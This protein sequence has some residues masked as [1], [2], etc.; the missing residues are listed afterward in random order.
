MSSN[1]ISN[2]I[3]DNASPPTYTNANVPTLDMDGNLTNLSNVS[4]TTLT[5]NGVNINSTE[6]GYL[7]GVVP[8]SVV[9]NKALVVDNANALSGLYYLSISGSNNDAFRISNSVSSGRASILFTNSGSRS[10]E[11]GLRG[12]A[13]STPANGFYIYDNA[14]SAYR[15][16]ID[17][18]G[19]V[20]IGA[21]SSSY[22]LHVVGNINTTT[23]YLLNDTSM[24]ASALTGVSDT[25][26][27]IASKALI[28]DSNKSI[29]GITSLTSTTL[30]G[31]T[32]NATSAYQ[33]NGTSMF[34]SAL[35]GVSN[36]SGAIA[37]KA[38][39]VDSNKSI[40]G[41]TSLTSTSLI[42]SGTTASTS[43][44][45]G[46][47]TVAGGVGVRGTLSGGGNTID[48][49]ATARSE[50]LINYTDTSNTFNNAFATTDTTPRY[51]YYFGAPTYTG[52]TARTTTTAA[53]M[54]ISGAPVSGT[55]N[56]ITNPYALIIGSG[57][58]SFG[59][60]TTYTTTNNADQ[61]ISIP[62]ITLTASG[63]ASPDSAHRSVLNI[64]AP[65]LTSSTTLTTTNAS[66]LYIAGPP[67]ASGSM[68]ITNAYSLYINSG[69]V[70]LGGN[71][72]T[73][74][75]LGVFPNAIP[76]IDTTRLIQ[77]IDSAQASASARAITLGRAYSSL[78]SAALLYSWTSAGS[79][80]NYVSLGL[81]GSS[82]F[83]NTLVVH[84]SGNVGV[85]TTSPSHLLDINGTARVAGSLT[86][87]GSGSH[88][89]AGTL[90][91]TLASGAQT[92]ITSVGTLSSLTVS[93]DV[94]ITTGKL[95]IGAGNDITSTI[96]SYIKSVSLGSA[97]ASTIVA[98][99]ASKN[100]SGINDLSS[101]EISLGGTA[102]SYT[103]A[104]VIATETVLTLKATTL[105]NTSAAGTDAIHRCGAYIKQPTISASNAVITTTASTVFIDGPPLTA[106]SATITNRYA[107]YAG[108]PMF[109]QGV[110]TFLSGSYTRAHRWSNDNALPITV[111]LQIFNGSNGTASNNALFGTTTGN[112]LSFMTNGSQRMTLD[113]SGNV[114]IGNAAPSFLLDVSGTTR[115]TGATTIG[116]ALTLTAGTASSSTSTGS[117]VITGGAGISGAVYIGGL[118]NIAGITT[119]TNATAS[120][121]V[122]TGALVVSGGV[123]IGGANYIGGALNVAGVASFTSGTTS[124][125]T[126]TGAVVVSGGVGISGA[127]YIGGIA[128]IAGIT[129]ITN[130]TSS[131][132]SS[133]GA[134]VVSG[135]VGIGGTLNIAGALA[136]SSLTSSGNATITGTLT[137]N[138]TGTNTIAGTLAASTLT[139][140]GNVTIT[141]T[142]TAN[143]IGTNTIAGTLAAST[144]TTSGSATFA[145]VLSANNTGTNT[146]A[147]TLASTNTTISGTLTVSGTGSH[148]IAG[149]L[150]TSTLNA[151]NTIGAGSTRNYTT[152]GTERA[153]SIQ[154]ATYTNNTTAAS[155]TDAA[156]RANV[157]LGPTTIAATNASVITTNASTLY[158]QDAPVAGTN[159][160]LSNR[161][162]MY[163]ASGMSY[164][165]GGVNV[166]GTL[167]ASG[168]TTISNNTTSS[169]ATSGAL[170]VTGGVGI[171][172]ALNVSGLITGTL[173]TAAQTNITSVGT[174]SN[175]TVSGTLTLGSTVVSAS[176][177][178]VVDS[179][180]AGTASANKAL[181]VDSSRD[182][183]NINTLSGASISLSGTVNDT[184]SLTNTNT[185]GRA[186]IKFTNDNQF[187]ELGLRGST[188]GPAN[189]FYIYNQSTYRLLI[190]STGKVGINTI[191]PAYQLDVNGTLNCT[192]LYINGSLFN[193]SGIPSYCSGIT[194][195][196]T[197]VADKVLT[198]NSALNVS[199]INSLSATNITGTLQTAAQTNITSVGTLTGLSLSGA[200]SSTSNILIYSANT[201][202]EDTVVTNGYDLVINNQDTTTAEQCGIAF[203][204]ATQSIST[205]TPTCAIR[206]F[207]SG[208]NGAGG[209]AFATRDSTTQSAS[210]ST[211]LVITGSGNVGIGT[212]APA[213][214]YQFDVAGRGRFATGLSVGTSTQTQANR[215]LVLIDS[216]QANSD[217]RVMMIGKEISAY[218]CGYVRYVHGANSSTTANYI[219]LG[220]HSRDDII[221]CFSSGRVAVNSSSNP[222]YTFYVNGTAGGTSAYTNASDYRL[223]YDLSNLDY[224]LDIVK[225]LKPIKFMQKD[226]P[227]KHQIG[228]LAHEVQEYI[229]EIVSHNKDEID[230]NG[231]PVYQSMQYALLTPVLVKAVQEQQELIETLQQQL[232]NAM[233]ELADIKSR[234]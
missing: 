101:N 165:G 204:C 182:I 218:N 96:A 67:A 206:A 41:I 179:V 144:L 192:S 156:H 33:L 49:T 16:I 116:G 51:T 125:S 231:N 100:F 9:G 84:G 124:S 46:A 172:G 72:L 28:V 85:G 1:N 121:S 120:S 138:N 75:L 66:T 227:D 2:D 207:R 202:F 62:A 13:S 10:F 234:L 24:F 113:I 98:L 109:T 142:L 184:L 119:L 63:I 209:I 27:A 74:K 79:T 114:G 152:A 174:L 134:L 110:S 186:S 107:L 163:V 83:N 171:G 183:S 111:D 40:T 18:S 169:N 48:Y 60:S 11:L 143:N 162:A 181:I 77:A 87:S 210:C 123:G 160:T 224:G 127:T 150:A 89:I 126:T 34:A 170:V 78:D 187:V 70:Y 31:T 29:T 194:T 14:N 188:L 86:V 30:I 228:F 233:N 198:V 54:M 141:G 97:V 112:F 140:S 147:G 73:N 122:S 137:A 225:R 58:S 221:S 128:N 106:G 118:T 136:A 178:A 131:T 94:S 219:S 52:T 185:G 130:S 157:Y 200:T 223:K 115:I 191:A 57:R 45:T 146:I 176:E 32:I 17:A 39:I 47:L 153:L 4:T 76:T 222:T 68:A 196:G 12:P 37:S 161:Y 195:T 197:A 214:D 20:A 8:G 80:S 108:G 104:S 229:P 189:S 139:A 133:T 164:L 226:Y 145:G 35:T 90:S 216:T 64:G 208:L 99:D 23:G 25:S 50:S 26:G 69:N 93:G 211:K 159:M 88:T 193:A 117:L 203:L 212:T 168:I 15:L 232:A 19:N 151:S 5:V 36:T 71:V 190:D 215:L 155:G 220:I 59:G 56:T 213:V 105:T 91:A 217:F 53:T 180:V 61:V 22:P 82:S 42:V 129:S 38:L 230:E 199:G 173:A 175:L 44:A 132:S 3:A 92:G 205:T 65:T 158:I 148:S 7:D 149:T 177:L 81:F 154:S 95:T 135:G 55:N 6:I 21:N 167:A 166:I 201:S 43:S 102:I 103:S